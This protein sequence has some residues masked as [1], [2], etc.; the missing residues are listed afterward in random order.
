M[1]RHTSMWLAK[2]WKQSDLFDQLKRFLWIR[3]DSFIFNAFELQLYEHKNKQFEYMLPTVFPWCWS[4]V[5][6]RWRVSYGYIWFPSDSSLVWFL[7]VWVEFSPCWHFNAHPGIRFSPPSSPIGQHCWFLPSSLE[8]IPGVSLV[9]TGSSSKLYTALLSTS[10]EFRNL[11][12]EYP[13]VI[14]YKGFSA[15]VSKHPVRHSVPTVPGPPVFAKARQYSAFDRELFA[16]YSALRRFWFLQEGKEFVLFTDHKPLTHT[17]FRTSPPWSTMQ[18]CCLSFLSEFNCDVCHL[19]GAENVVADA[20]SHPDLGKPLTDVISMSYLPIP[21]SPKPSVSR[22]LRCLSC[23]HPLYLLLFQQYLRLLCHQF[24]EY[25]IPRCYCSNSS[26]LRFKTSANPPPWRL[27]LFSFLVSNFSVMFQ[28]VFSVLWFQSQWEEKFLSP[29][30][31]FL[32]LVN[33][34]TGDLFPGVLYGSSCPDMSSLS[35]ISSNSHQDS[36]SPYPD[37]RTKILPHSCGPGWTSPS[38]IIP[39]DVWRQ[40]LSSS[41]QQKIVQESSYIHGSLFSESLQ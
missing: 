28:Q 17:L 26:V 8:L 3:Y 25:H 32:I 27:S 38:F 36:S 39:W 24:H 35:C 2:S 4:T 30:T 7:P 37:S 6:N 18:Q 23:W 10:E 12:A 33:K 19:S 31:K 29:S 22:C 41:L 5:K 14:F 16:A 20:L 40:S 13:D 1:I 15:T 34:P 11:L 9:P 21:K